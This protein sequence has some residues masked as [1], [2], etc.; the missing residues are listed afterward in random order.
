MRKLTATLIVSLLGLIALSVSNTAA[1]CGDSAGSG[2][3][4]PK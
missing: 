3:S 4:A 1:A 2:Y